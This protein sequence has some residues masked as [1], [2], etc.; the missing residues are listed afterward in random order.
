MSLFSWPSKSRRGKKYKILERYLVG[1]KRNKYNAVK[2]VVD[3]ITFDSKKEARRYS[4]LLLLEKAGEIANIMVH[5][6]FNLHVE[7]VKIGKYELDFGCYD[8]K[9]DEMIYEDVKGWDKKK[10]KWIV[11]PL[12]AWKKKHVEA[13]YGIKV[14]YV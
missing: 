13:E 10:N 11:T 1:N 6:F 2:T 8:Q 14:N 5:P 7:G 9:T 4:E 3:G 12:S